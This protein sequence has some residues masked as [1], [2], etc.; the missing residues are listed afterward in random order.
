[1]KALFVK[2]KEI[3]LYVF[4][5]G[6]TTL[7]NLGVYFL[8]TRCFFVNEFVSNAIAWLLS[9]LFA[10]VTNKIWV[11]DS[12]SREGKVLLFEISSFFAARLLSLGIDMAVLWLGTSVLHINDGIVKI[13][14]NVIVII[15]N[16]IASKLFIFRKKK[17]DE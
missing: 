14:A 9:V 17:Q 4:F 7:V 1:M 10:F 3:I 13:V 6:C 15:V 2:Y 5:G 16:Y 12:R 8:L 11:F